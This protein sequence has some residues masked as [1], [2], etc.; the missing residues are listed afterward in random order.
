MLLVSTAVTCMCD[1]RLA[2]GVASR[3]QRTPKIM[4]GRGPM[5][6]ATWPIVSARRTLQPSSLALT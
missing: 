4:K 2:S 3:P 5:G 6:G 1:G